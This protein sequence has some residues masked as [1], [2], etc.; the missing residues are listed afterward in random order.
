M[1]SQPFKIEV[2]KFGISLTDPNVQDACAATIADFDDFTCNITSGQLT[3]SS[4][5]SDET[6]P[7][8]WCDP[9]QTTPSVG[10]TSYEAAI[11]FLQ[12]PQLVAGLSR[13]LF[14]HDTEIAW[15]FMGLDGDNP[16]KAVAK[17]RLTSGSF[18]GEA[19]VSLTAEATMPCD[20]R[21]VICFGDI[22]SSESVGGPIL[23]TGATEVVGGPGTW[24]PAGAVAPN[25]LADMGAV[26]ATPVTVWSTG[27]HMVLG[28]ASQAHWNGTAWVVGMAPLVGR[29]TAGAGAGTAP[30]S[31]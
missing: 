21:P 11:S 17:V 7:A 18:G 8:T 14:E 25:A 15:V 26:T 3:G 20:G 9:E 27:S 31:R 24:T 19:R 2:G 1:P 30:S 29:E 13:T 4:N 6:T 10:A 28:D 12:D 23:A 16:P 5:I 22:T